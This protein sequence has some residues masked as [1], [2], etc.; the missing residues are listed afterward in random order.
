MCWLGNILVELQIGAGRQNEEDERRKKEE[1]RRRR[2]ERRRKGHP[3]II[4][5][6][7]THI[8]DRALSVINYQ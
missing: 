2:G 6:V 5:S 4:L 7:I 3:L 8:Q 1:S